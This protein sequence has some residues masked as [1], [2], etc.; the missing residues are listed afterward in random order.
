MTHDRDA[1]HSV[2]DLVPIDLYLRLEALGPELFVVRK[3]AVYAP[4][5]EPYAIHAEDDLV[6]L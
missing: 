3:L 4:S 6:L 2:E 1:P 5:R